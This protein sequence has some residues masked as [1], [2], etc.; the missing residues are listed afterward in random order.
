V[1]GAVVGRWTAPDGSHDWR[2]I[3]LVPAAM[4]FVVLIG[5]ALLFRPRAERAA[6]A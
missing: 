6:A 5:F 2:T 3:W 4:A 1:S